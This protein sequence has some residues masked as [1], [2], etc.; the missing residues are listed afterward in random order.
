MKF[1]YEQRNY[2]YTHCWMVKVGPYRQGVMFTSKHGSEPSRKRRAQAFVKLRKWAMQAPTQRDRL[3]MIRERRRK[4]TATA[5]S[6]RTGSRRAS[7][8]ASL[9]R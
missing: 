7:P 2:G 1:H 5:S 4:L 6:R 9:P 8:R 3:T